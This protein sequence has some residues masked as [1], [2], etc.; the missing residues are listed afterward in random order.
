MSGSYPVSDIAHASLVQMNEISRRAGM[1]FALGNTGGAAPRGDGI[2]RP[3]NVMRMMANAVGLMVPDVVDAKDNARV[4][5][6][7]MEILLS[8]VNGMHSRV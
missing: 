4:E 6:E 7:L 5:V 8:G 1:S 3:N 2:D